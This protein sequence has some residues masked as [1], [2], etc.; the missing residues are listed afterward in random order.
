MKSRM[1]LFSAQ[2]RLETGEDVV[3]GSE[4][5][6]QE[7]TLE[8]ESL[9]INPVIEAQQRERLARLRETRDAQRAAE[10]LSQL[11]TA[12]RGSENLMPL[13][14]TC[15]ENKLTL[16]EICNLLRSVW[17]EYRAPSFI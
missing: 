1:P 8:L 16:G 2:R 5:I 3:V 10:L 11:E 4:Q 6:Q 13:F 15:I 12:A 14:I 17:G 7:E 9:R